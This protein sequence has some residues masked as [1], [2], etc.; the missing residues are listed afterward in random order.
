MIA[1]FRVQLSSIFLRQILW[2]NDNFFH[3]TASVSFLPSLQYLLTY[4][5]SLFNDAASTSYYVTSIL[6]LY[7]IQSHI[8]KEEKNN[9][10]NVDAED[11]RQV[12]NTL[13]GRVV[14]KL[15]VIYIKHIYVST[16]TS[17]VDKRG[18][19]S[20]FLRFVKSSLQIHLIWELCSMTR[21][22]IFYVPMIFS[23][24]NIFE[25]V[26]QAYFGQL[27]SRIGKIWLCVSG[28]HNHKD[29]GILGCDAV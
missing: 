16:H 2:S 1:Q 12:Q 25:K 27:S 6:I 20:L 29:H 23:R 21:D 11:T 26:Q 17:T 18:L 7:M 3:S 5:Y 10:I 14:S 19:K 28:D 13:V 15:L 8:Q 24:E 9:S 4:I 22:I